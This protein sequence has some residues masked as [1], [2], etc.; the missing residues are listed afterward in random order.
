MQATRRTG[1]SDGLE[2]K[3]NLRQEASHTV[4]IPAVA[5]S[6]VV[7]LLHGNDASRV[8]STIG[9]LLL[10]PNMQLHVYNNWSCTVQ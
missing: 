6:N 8:H 9:H 4:F 3:F 10:L 1:P 2:Y 5:S 7:R